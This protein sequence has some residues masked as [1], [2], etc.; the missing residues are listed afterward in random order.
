MI[1]SEKKEG[2]KIVDVQSGSPGFEAG[3]KKGDIVLEIEGKEIKSLPD[4]VRIS[5]EIKNRTYSLM[6]FQIPF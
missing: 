6:L 1:F 4:Y 3:L 2:L 5:R